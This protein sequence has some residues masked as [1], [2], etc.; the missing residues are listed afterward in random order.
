MLTAKYAKRFR[1]I[2][3]QAHEQPTNSPRGAIAT[4]IA[5]A[6]AYPGVAEAIKL[7]DEQKKKLIDG[8]A[9]AEVLTADQSERS[10][11]GNPIEA[12]RTLGHAR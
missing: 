2:M 3:L 4:T 6:A 10:L 12:Q 9:T 11:M 7:T 8:T 5:S 1:Q